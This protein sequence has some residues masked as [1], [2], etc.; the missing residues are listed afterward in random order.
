M[1]L[2][3]SIFHPWKD[4]K[5]SAKLRSEFIF[6][7]DDPWFIERAI[8]GTRKRTYNIVKFKSVV[9]YPDMH[10]YRETYTHVTNLMHFKWEVT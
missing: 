9:I 4:L 3:T 6:A 10:Y 2:V 5:A 8:K 7:H 1:G